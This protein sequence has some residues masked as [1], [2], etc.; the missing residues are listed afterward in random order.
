MCIFIINASQ[1]KKLTIGTGRSSPV[2]LYFNT[3]KYCSC[4]GINKLNL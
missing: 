4:F 1:N 3:G 2:H